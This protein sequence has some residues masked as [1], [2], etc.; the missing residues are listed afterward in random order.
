[1]TVKEIKEGMT[2]PEVA[3]TIKENFDA[4]NTEK[5]TVGNVGKVKESVDNANK[6]TGVSNYPAFSATEDVAVGVVRNYNGLLYRS[7][8]AGANE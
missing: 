8:V 1:M 3:Q 2:A 5:E 6:N 7:I 4:L